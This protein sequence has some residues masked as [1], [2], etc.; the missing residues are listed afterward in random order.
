MESGDGSSSLPA[1]ARVFDPNVLLVEDLS[2]LTVPTG[3][4]AL[5]LVTSDFLPPRFSLSLMVLP[6]FWHGCG[7]DV[8]DG[9][10]SVRPEE[11]GPW[12]IERRGT[13][14]RAVFG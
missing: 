10:A 14:H 9:E 7:R 2:D 4:N 12:Q 6:H 8:C 13:Q 3:E 5:E 1:L 11:L